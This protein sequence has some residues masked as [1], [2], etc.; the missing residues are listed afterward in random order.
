MRSA[1]HQSRIPDRTN[2]WCLAWQIA[3]CVPNS[4]E[5][6]QPP[7]SPPHQS[8]V[9]TPSFHFLAQRL[10]RR[11]PDFSLAR[12]HSRPTQKGRCSETLPSWNKATIIEQVNLW[13]LLAKW[14]VRK[15]ISRP[16][17]R[18]N[19]ALASNSS[20]K[21]SHNPEGSHRLFESE[22]GVYL[23]P[24]TTQISHQHLRTIT[25]CRNPIQ[26]SD[27]FRSWLASD[28]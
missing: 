12:S 1:R 8:N 23:V 24:L 25:Q 15:P 18:K 20:S 2:F 9:G 7:T 19:V 21:S 11:P 17:Q 22:M 6:P 13:Y 27:R 26:P 10:A 28:S 4:L 5:L 16:R 3:S 14:E